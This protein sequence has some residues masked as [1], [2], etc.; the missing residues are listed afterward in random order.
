[1]MNVFSIK[2]TGLLPRSPESTETHG[3]STCFG[4]YPGW[5]AWRPHLP[6]RHAQ[7]LS[8]MPAALQMQARRLLTVAGAAHFHGGAWR[9]HVVFPV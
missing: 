6:A 8:R 5:Q 1:M 2:G 3:A 9:G 4:R 7:W